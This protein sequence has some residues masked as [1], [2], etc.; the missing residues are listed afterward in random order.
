MSELE[1]RGSEALK[2]II[3]ESRKQG[4]PFTCI[5]YSILLPW[6]ATVARSL[7]VP[8]VLLWI[9]PAVVFALYY[10]YN[11]GYYDQIQRVISSDDPNS[12]S[13]K[14]PGLPLL[15]ARDL[16]SFFGSSDVYDFALPI[17]RRQFELLEEENNPKILINTFE[18]L[19]KDAVRA[20]KKFHLMP[21]GPLIPSAFLDGNGPSEASSGC[22]LFRCT[23][24]YIDW[25]NSKP[26]AS[27]IYVSSGSIS[28]L[29]KQQKEE[30]ARGLLSTKRP[31]LWVIRDIEEEEE[32]ALSFKEEL[33]TQGKIVPWCS[34]LEVL[35]SPATG[36][37]LTHCGWNSCLESLGC[38]VPTV[39]FPQWTDQA[40]NAKIVRDLSET[41]VRLE[42]AEDGVVKGEEIERCLELVMGDSE[43]GEEAANANGEKG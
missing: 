20:I 1:H 24:S 4:Q 33:E 42:A 5:V 19:E 14:L 32:D 30:I 26:K 18:E 27:V 15:T 22:D 11:N 38:G 35:S 28:T 13:I 37:F 36:C 8:S 31:F 23:S 21:I 7:H 39:A 41:G 16:P 34:Q 10:Y 29:S 2:N 17:F 25:L 43:K 12:M 9:Q 40:T 3:E 6:V